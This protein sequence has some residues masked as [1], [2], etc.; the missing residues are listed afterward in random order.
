[1]ATIEQV[2]A[3]MRMHFEDN[4]ERFRTIALQ[5]AAH[6]AKIGH[7]ASA[8]EIKDLVLSSKQTVR[9][10]VVKYSGKYDMI[11]QRPAD[12]AMSD[13][14]LS[15]NLEDRIKRIV[16]E[17]RKKELL[18]KNGLKNR[19]KIMLTGEPGTG[20]TMTASVLANELGL[21]LNVIQIEKLVTKYMGETSVKLR[22][23]FDCIEEI[24]GVYLFDEF[25]AIGSD[26]SLD[27]D[28][29][30]MRR[31]LNSFL[32]FL[33]NDDS[34]SVIIAATNNPQI[35]DKALFRRFDDVLDYAI[36]D[37][38]QIQRIMIAKLD[39]L[40][41][42]DIFKK[43]MYQY[44]VGLSHA[45]IVRACEEA[46]KYSLIYEEKITRKLLQVCIQDRKSLYQFREA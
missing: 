7:A 36:P 23:V 30:E 25:D 35:L 13:L 14:I 33:E 21:P 40:V 3:L 2:K 4:D 9:R 27:N 42:E 46:V 34:Y 22:Q 39:G 6:E 31:I 15:E 45:D 10:K 5:I 1:M 29:G 32:Q 41:A 43:Q 17:Y 18:R 24:Q 20:K 19:S 38:Q 11:E 37:E 16:T 26:R 28:V 8:R 12:A 44:M